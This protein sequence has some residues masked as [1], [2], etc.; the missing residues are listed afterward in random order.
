MSGAGRGKDKCAD[1]CGF[2]CG[3]YWSGSSSR[4]ARFLTQTRRE[5]A[6]D[7]Y[8]QLGYKA[9]MLHA[10]VGAAFAKSTCLL[11]VVS[12]PSFVYTFAHGATGLCARLAAS[13]KSCVSTA[14]AGR[15]TYRTTL[16][17]IKTSYSRHKVSFPS[18]PG[19]LL[20]RSTLT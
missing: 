3:Y 11:I 1:E 5:C 15:W 7:M 12:G 10:N 19:M 13:C 8:R 17:R 4:C 2:G 20:P 14:S 9:T 18:Q 6:A 16:P